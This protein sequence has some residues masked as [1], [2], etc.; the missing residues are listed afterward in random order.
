[1]SLETEAILER[2]RLRRGISVWRALAVLAVLAAFGFAALSAART[3]GWTSNRQIARISVEGLITEDR[4][5]IR[6]LKKIA[7]AKY[8]KGL[9]VFVNSP[10]GTTTGGEALFSALR[11][12]AKVK[13]VV[14]QFGTLATSAAY[15]T[16]LATD[17][18]VARGNTITG[19]VG[20]IFQW[21]EVSQLLDKVGVKMNEVKSGPLKAN[22]SPFQ[23]L[24]PQGKAVAEQ[25]VLESQRWFVDLVATRR[26]IKTADIPGLEQGRIFSGREAL[27]YRMIDEIGGEEDAVKWMED[28]RNVSKGLKVIDWKPERQSAWSMARV[29]SSIAGGLFGDGAGA[30]VERIA[31]TPA[32]PLG[33]DGLLSV[34]QPAKNE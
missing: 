28:K 33:L 11:D 23:P 24:D 1:M 20:V 10:G 26:S 27:G 25:M 4:D 22:P 7:E 32:L 13:P 15:I 6:M 2:R 9:I 29:A 34:W 18:I 8:V 21:A 5:Q 12:V 30:L 3:A 17:H 31:Q 14:A 16:G 19:S